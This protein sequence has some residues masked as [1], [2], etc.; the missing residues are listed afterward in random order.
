MTVGGETLSKKRSGNT[1]LDVVPFTPDSCF[2][3]KTHPGPNR[4]RNT[5]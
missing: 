1:S 4:F 5:K 3:R 2:G